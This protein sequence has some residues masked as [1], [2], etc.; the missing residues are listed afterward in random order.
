VL[1]GLLGLSLLLTAAGWLALATEAGGR[2]VVLRLLD[3][4]PGLALESVSGTLLGPLELAGLDFQHREAHV[5]AARL[6]VRW[7]PAELWRGRLRL[8]QVA[9]SGLDVRKH[10][11]P[12][13]ER[14]PDLRPAIPLALDHLTLDGVRLA[15][16]DGA[17]FLFDHGEARDV[18]LGE[19]LAVGDLALRAPALSI[20]L[21]GQLHPFAEYRL[22]VAAPWRWQQPGR[23]PLDGDLRLGGSLRAL[24]ATLGLRGWLNADAV[25]RLGD[26]L[27]R[28][29]LD[30]TAE[31]D[32]LELGADD[33]LPGVTGRVQL[34]G[35]L[36][37]PELCASLT[38]L[39]PGADPVELGIAGVL[40]PSRVRLDR[41][42]ALVLGGTLQGSGEWSRGPAPAGVVEWTA[43]ALDPARH[44]PEWPGRLAGAGVLQIDG[45]AA[46]LVPDLRID[47][48]EGT[49]RGVPF[50]A[51][52]RVGLPAGDL[53]IEG[54]EVRSGTARLEATGTLASDWDLRWAL[55]APDLSQALPGASGALSSRGSLRGPRARPDAEAEVRARDLSWSGYR[56]RTLE[57]RL[58]AGLTP[59]QSFRLEVRGE[60]LRAA[61]VALDR[62]R[63]EG[64]GRTADHRVS[65]EASGPAG[66]LRASLKGGL[67][68]GPGWRGTLESA[69]LRGEGW[70][71]WRTERP[72]VLDLAPERLSL[73][74]LCWRDPR[75][76]RLCGD[77]GREP[78]GVWSGRLEGKG[79]ALTPLRP[80]LPEG[81]DLE[82]SAGLRA[83]ATVTEK[84]TAAGEATLT[85]AP[86]RIAFRAGGQPRQV[87]Y[88]EA[89]AQARL[90]ERALVL[91]FDLPAPEVGS[92]RGQVTLTGWQP[93]RPLAPATPIQGS[94]ALSLRR[95]DLLESTL[96]ELEDLRG[97]V[98]ADLTLDGSLGRPLVRGRAEVRE[99]SLEVPRLGVRLTGLALALQ[100]PEPGVLTYEARALSGDRPLTVTGRTALDLSRGWPTTLRVR[101]E[102]VPAVNVP[103]ARVRLS[104]DLT[105]EVRG[106]R[107]ALG[108]TVR[109]PAADLRPRQLPDGAGARSDDV[110]VVR[111]GEAGRRPSPW[112]VSA[113]VGLVLGERVRVEGL[114]AQGR[115]EGTLQLVAEPGRL[116]LARGEV[117]LL[118]G[119]FR[120][121]GQDLKVERGRALYSNSPLDDPG[122]DVKAVRQGPDVLA[123]V[124][125]TGTLKAPQ[126]SLFSEPP[127]SQPDAFAYLLF[128]RK[129]REV[130]D[131]TQQS[132]A[133]TAAALG[134]SEQVGLSGALRSTLGIDSVGV[135]TTE[136]RTAPGVTAEESAVAIG[137]RLSP[138]LYVR[139]L[140]GLFETRDVVQLRYDLTPRVQVQSE[141][142]ARTGADVFFTIER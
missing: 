29:D 47:R 13:P 38:L 23:A 27:A 128:G 125:L 33:D 22:D 79:L 71:D 48:L 35:G 134:L 136:R 67:R 18:T 24:T 130:D 137:K 9:I 92:V 122:L 116:T 140:V 70:G 78:P 91:R 54:I 118:D 65:V 101:G 52:G 55:D 131:P 7:R 2:W 115:L 53:R 41:L 108:G 39:P 42:R 90:A 104:P 103:E 25:G 80:W 97:E 123:G 109:V 111:R 95:L 84:G 129:A 19:A 87:A 31:V 36:A 124:R 61:E 89:S 26:L 59:G 69:D 133:A 57:G 72:A 139:Y 51:R 16:G 120:A 105:V 113:D 30:V 99:G 60:G 5:R 11:I 102:D 62:L 121:H 110:V 66:E 32:R 100:T 94:V 50:T 43:E 15:F 14:L 132:M 75:G 1:G 64:S 6:T 8:E 49:L 85:L 86:G 119:V 82:G 112:L 34:T 58:Q 4:V 127:M 37:A 107:V 83:S 10:D 17:P 96:R 142:G 88:G 73:A 114:G 81:L 98:V 3:R 117:S 40:E 106:R 93:L 21:S 141:T 77:L 28:I 20:N 135:E 68:D 76:G 74:T 46:G 63:V 138:A 45:G 126:A 56:A 44:W 12:P